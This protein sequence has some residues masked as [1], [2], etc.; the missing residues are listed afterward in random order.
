MVANPRQKAKFNTYTLF[1]GSVNGRNKSNFECRI[2][3]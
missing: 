1:Y 2:N 3:T